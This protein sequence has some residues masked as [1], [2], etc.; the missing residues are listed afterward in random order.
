MDV[1]PT[2]KAIITYADFLRV[3]CIGDGECDAEDFGGYEVRSDGLFVIPKKSALP[4]SEDLAQINWHPTGHYDQPALALSCTVG[5]LRTFVSEGGLLGC[6]DEGALEEAL[7]AQAGQLTAGDAIPDPA[8]DA[9]AVPADHAN[10]T[11]WPLKKPKRFQGYGKPLY[12]FLKAAQVAGRPCPKPRDVLD[13][14]E[15]TPPPEVAKV[16]PDGRAALRVAAGME[17]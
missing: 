8:P 11:T 7:Y 15:A 13:A 17:P 14:W 12:N 6:I 9:K 4:G 3:C 16:L 10:G 1:S 2:D 5:Q